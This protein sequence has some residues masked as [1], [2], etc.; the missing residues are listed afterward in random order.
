MADTNEP[1]PTFFKSSLSLSKEPFDLT[2]SFR[3]PT[4]D[5]LF[6][7]EGNV[8]P[9]EAR[10]ILLSDTNHENMGV[11]LSIAQYLTATAKPGDTILLEGAAS[12]ERVD[13]KERPLLQNLPAEVRVI[14]WDDKDAYVEGERLYG[15]L[16][17][18]E[19]ELK[20]DEISGPEKMI[21][22]IKRGD[23]TGRINET[24]I[25]R[26]NQSLVRSLEG[27]FK[28]EGH[29][30]KVYVVLGQDHLTADDRVNQFSQTVPHVV[31]TPKW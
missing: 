16:E 5:T 12:G 9:D 14:G 15:E 22:R 25:V 17:Q 29:S 31:L 3:P 21:L 4:V 24:V 23:L 19:R 30:E 8:K 10:L 11:G 27:M 1:K 7:I 28:G 6:D 13:L 18:L 26:R 20:S 2:G